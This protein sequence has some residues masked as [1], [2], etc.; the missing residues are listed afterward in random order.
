MSA[1]TPTGPG[2]LAQV[3][4]LEHR[5]AGPH[6][7]GQRAHQHRLGK[8]L[9]RGVCAPQHHVRLVALREPGQTVLHRPTQGVLAQPAPAQADS[10]EWHRDSDCGRRDRAAPGRSATR[11]APRGG[12]WP[13]S[14]SHVATC[15]RAAAGSSRG[16]AATRAAM[17]RSASSALLRRV[18]SHAVI[19]WCDQCGVSQP[20]AIGSDGTCTDANGTNGTLLRGTGPRCMR[21]GPKR[22]RPFVSERAFQCDQRAPPNRSGGAD[23]LT[24]ST[25]LRAAGCG[26]ACRLPQT[27]R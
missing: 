8:R 26:C 23:L 6:A 25:D 20:M 13:S 1:H 10:A 22:K 12:R 21:S 17:R 14:S 9:L 3:A 7:A 27:P 19:A 24:R 2:G 11:P 5:G 15:A 4:P 16:S 18:L